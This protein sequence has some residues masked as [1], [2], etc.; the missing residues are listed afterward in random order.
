MIEFYLLQDGDKNA[1]EACPWDSAPSSPSAQE[2]RFESDRSA[3]LRQP[4]EQTQTQR[5]SGI[6]VP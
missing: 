6:Q 3:A 2:N 1:E 4:L 5:I